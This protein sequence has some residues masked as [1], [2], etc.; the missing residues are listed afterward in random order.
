MKV[1]IK[2][3]SLKLMKLLITFIFIT[4]YLHAVFKKLYISR[5]AEALNVLVK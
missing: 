5:H 2:V 3:K 4:W 1:R